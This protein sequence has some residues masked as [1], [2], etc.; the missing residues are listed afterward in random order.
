MLGVVLAGWLISHVNGQPVPQ[1]QP[2]PIVM[3]VTCMS[4]LNV[5][6]DHA[7][8]MQGVIWQSTATSIQ[9]WLWRN[10][11]VALH[12]PLHQLQHV[13]EG[14]LMSQIQDTPDLVNQTQHQAHTCQNSLVDLFSWTT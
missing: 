8:N 9:E 12:E 6:S 7:N 2:D 14:M 11:P 13:L 1:G 5:A 4:V 10:V 3:L